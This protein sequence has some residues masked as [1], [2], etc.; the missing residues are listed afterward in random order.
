MHKQEITEQQKNQPTTRQRSIFNDAVNSL[1]NMAINAVNTISEIYTDL[2][3]AKLIP[4]SI[5]RMS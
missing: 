4:F 2:Q 3:I 1:L 5:H